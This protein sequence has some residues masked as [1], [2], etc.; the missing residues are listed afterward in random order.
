MNNMAAP[1]TAAPK[2]TAVLF[3]VRRPEIDR[4]ACVREIPFLK[5]ASETFV[6]VVVLCTFRRGLK[7]FL[8]AGASRAA[9]T[10]EGLHPEQVGGAW[11]QIADLHRV[12]LKY[13]HGVGSHIQVIILEDKLSK[14]KEKFNQK[15][16]SVEDGGHRFNFSSTE[17]KLMPLCVI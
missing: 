12:L 8:H 9:V 11:G 5:N 4:K 3:W 1:P 6:A 2:M 14:V 17:L 13:E 7:L 16:I 15:K 10:A